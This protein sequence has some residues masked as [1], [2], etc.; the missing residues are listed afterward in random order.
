M[1]IITELQNTRQEIYMKG[2]SYS[3]IAFSLIFIQIACQNSE[4]SMVNETP[5]A[6]TRKIVADGFAYPVGKTE[7]VTQAKDKKDEWYNALDFGEN[8]HLGE[9]WNKNTGGNSDCGETVYAIA[10]GVITYAG[11]AGI[12]WGNVVIIEHNLP[13]GSRV[14]S[15]YGHLQKIAKNSGE[16]KKREKIGTIGNADGKYLCHLH[17]EIRSENCPMWNKTGSGYSAENEGWLDPSD[18]IDAQRRK[19]N[20]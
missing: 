10:D 13:D 20:H 14:Q 8:K 18:F 3:I 19:Q 15:L 17:L 4:S 5:P 9:D 12:S 6:Q 2:T 16:V 11:N 7:T 1:S